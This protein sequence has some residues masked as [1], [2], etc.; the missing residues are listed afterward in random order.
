M[1]DTSFLKI[2]LWSFTKSLNFS[3]T[4]LLYTGL[5]VHEIYC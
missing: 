2:N 1:K 4:N 3:M 5:D